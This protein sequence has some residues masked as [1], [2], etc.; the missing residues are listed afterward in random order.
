MIGA[1]NF[2]PCYKL[3]KQKKHTYMTKEQKIRASKF[4]NRLSARNF[5]TGYFSPMKK[6][7]FGV[8]CF[9]YELNPEFS[10][11]ASTLQYI[12]EQNDFTVMQ[13]SINPRKFLAYYTK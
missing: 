3:Y 6:N 8:Y 10:C 12:I 11:F 5:R 1:W 9:D 7:K 4:Y 13:S 2:R